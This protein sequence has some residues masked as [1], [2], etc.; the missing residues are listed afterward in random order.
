MPITPAPKYVETGGSVGFL[1]SSV[2]VKNSSAGTGGYPASKGI[3]R[4]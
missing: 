3:G 4:E 1:T 2:A